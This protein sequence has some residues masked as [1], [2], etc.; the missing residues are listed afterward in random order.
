M[1]GTVGIEAARLEEM[2]YE[3]VKASGIAFG[4]AHNV[5]QRSLTKSKSV[6]VSNDQTTIHFLAIR[7]LSHNLKNQKV[8]EKS[9]KKVMKTKSVPHNVKYKQHSFERDLLLE[10]EGDH[11]VEHELNHD[12]LDLVQVA[13]APV[14]PAMADTTTATSWP[15]A[16]WRRTILATRRMRSVPAI[17]VPPNF[18]TRS[19]MAPPRL[20]VKPPVP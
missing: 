11:D 4:T 9:R 8:L 17:D 10:A 1:G 12:D 6:N 15:A 5:L 7:Q 2:D 13:A 19:G 3:T 20:P 18:I 14:S 16:C